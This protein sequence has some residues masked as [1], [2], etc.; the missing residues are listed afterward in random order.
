MNDA[1][2]LS[3]LEERYAYLQK[4]TA[5]Q[6]KVVMQLADELAKLRK[7]LGAMRAQQHAPRASDDVVDE[8]PPHY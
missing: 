2:R 6:D 4:H 8:K 7:E 1:D 5:E 3:R